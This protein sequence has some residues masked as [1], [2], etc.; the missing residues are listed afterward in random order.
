MMLG[1][2]G[3]AFAALIALFAPTVVGQITRVANATAFQAAVDM[4]ATYIEV[5]EHLDLTNAG[6]MLPL[7]PGPTTLSILVR[8]PSHG[9]KP[10]AQ[11]P[12]A[13]L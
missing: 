4:G 6:G 2:G 7:M 1:K 12:L 3:S 10:T 5:V 8:S 13:C 9:V 11:P